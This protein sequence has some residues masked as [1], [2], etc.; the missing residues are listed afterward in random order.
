MRIGGG[1]LSPVRFVL[2]NPLN[3]RLTLIGYANGTIK[4][5]SLENLKS[6]TEYRI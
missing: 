3:S 5:V 2:T 1:N 4:V 6:D